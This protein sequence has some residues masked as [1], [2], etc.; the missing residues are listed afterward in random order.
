[1]IGPPSLNAL[2][3]KKD[4]LPKKFFGGPVGKDEETIEKE[5]FPWKTVVRKNY[6][7][8]FVKGELFLRTTELYPHNGR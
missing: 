6:K 3:T 4:T 5:H 7:S 8:R 1:M 2:Y